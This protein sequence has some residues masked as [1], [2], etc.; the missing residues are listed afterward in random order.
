MFV[1]VFVF[2]CR[3]LGVGMYMRVRVLVSPPT[4]IDTIRDGVINKSEWFYLVE[5]VVVATFHS[6][7][8]GIEAKDTPPPRRD[9]LKQP[10][11]SFLRESRVN[12]SDNVDN[13]RY[14]C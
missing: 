14:I 6:S 12:S 2:V 5:F 9:S 11:G 3:L 10:G 4:P 7:K 13:K 8:T 1:F